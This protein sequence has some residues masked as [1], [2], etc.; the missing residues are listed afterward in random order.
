LEKILK[1]LLSIITVCKNE[2]F[3]E[4]TC[5]SIC[6]QSCSDFEWIII[7]GASTDDTLTKMAPYHQQAEIFISEPDTGI[8]QAMNKGIKYSKGEYLLF[9]NGGDLLYD[10]NT[11]AKVLPYL[12]QKKAGVF[13]GD[14][15]RLFEKEA[16]CFIKTYPDKLDKSFFLTNTLGHQSCYIQKSLFQKWG[17]Y[18]EDFRIV[19]DK[20]KWL[21]F[22][23]HD[24]TFQHIPFA[25]SQFRM[26][27][28]SRMKSDALKEEKRKM[29][30][31]Y[32][33]QEV[34]IS[35]LDNKNISSE[36]VNKKIRELKINQY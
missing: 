2:Q 35:I 36:P 31:Q 29:L 27:G 9:L 21:C 10:K 17:N 7:D 6:E 24:V 8:Y 30:L 16:D 20:E 1:N 15:Y 32:Y 12:K 25:C 22:L 5:K 34:V 33:P 4:S 11:I 28:L 19:S 14:S 18:R 26:N 23:E 3:I 13:Y